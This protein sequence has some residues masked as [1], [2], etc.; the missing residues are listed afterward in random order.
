M[1]MDELSRDISQFEDYMQS[2]EGIDPFDGREP[3]EDDLMNINI[4]EDM[5]ASIYDDPENNGEEDI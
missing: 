3:S 1:D 2:S 4:N 5:P